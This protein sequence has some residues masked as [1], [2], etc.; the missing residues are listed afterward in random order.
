MPHPFGSVAVADLADL[1]VQA[2]VESSKQSIEREHWDRQKQGR[3]SESQ[4]NSDFKK[5]WW[6]YHGVPI[7]VLLS[8]VG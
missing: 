5:V 8:L 6:G 3:P 4:R 7:D 1:A 2:A